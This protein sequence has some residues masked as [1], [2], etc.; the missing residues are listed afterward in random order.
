MAALAVVTLTDVKT[1]LR[2]PNPTATSADDNALLKFIAAADEVISYECDQILPKTYSERHNGGRMSI[3]LRKVPVIEVQNVEES[4][5]WINY[6]LDYQDPGSPSPTSMFAYSLDHPETGEITRRSVANVP[7]PFQPGEDNIFV[8]YVAG[9]EIAPGNVVLAELE[10]IAHWWQASQLRAGNTG[11]GA[12]GAAA[13]D[14]TLG[15]QYS[16]DTESGTQN[17]NIGVPFRIL[18]LIKKTRHMPFIA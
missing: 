1:H 4:W 3:F 8:Q 12:P 11:A 16:R 18:E 2:Y 13:Y 6:E 17:I 14:A 15:Q 10:L 9:Y 5:G 7:R